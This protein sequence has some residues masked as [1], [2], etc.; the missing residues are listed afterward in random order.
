MPTIQPQKAIK[1]YQVIGIG[2]EIANVFS[3]YNSRYRKYECL[4]V[5]NH[6][7]VLLS[8]DVKP[9]AIVYDYE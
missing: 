2:V 8:V 4:A 1:L 3:G 5:Y 9:L 7:G 6:H